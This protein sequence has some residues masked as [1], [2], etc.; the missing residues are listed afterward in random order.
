[1]TA[2]VTELLAAGRTR[3]P[4]SYRQQRAWL[5]PG[6]PMTIGRQAVA[7]IQLSIVGDTCVPR[8]VVKG[9]PCR[10]SILPWAGHA[11]VTLERGQ[12]QYVNGHDLMVR[13]IAAELNDRGRPARMLIELAA[14]SPRAAQGWPA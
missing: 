2:T 8:L 9:K 13:P 11:T 3:V 4:N 1:M 7:E 12:W 5:Q 10:R 6:V 14:M